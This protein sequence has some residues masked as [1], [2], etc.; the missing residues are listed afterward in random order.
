MMN[1]NTNPPPFPNGWYTIELTK[2]VQKGQI[3]AHEFCGEQVIVY[4]TQSGQA[5]V[6]EAYCPHMGAHFAHGGHVSGN[7]VVCPF[8][9]FCFDPKGTCTKTG[10]GKETPLNV[11]TRTW[12]VREQNGVIL[13][14]HNEDPTAKPEWEIPKLEDDGW[15]EPQFQ[16]W[17]LNSNPQEI[18]E[19]SVDF[20]HFSLVHGYSEVKI[21]NPLK[22]DGPYLYAKYG[23]S[24]VANFIGKGGKKVHVEFDITQNGLGY[25]AV[26]AHVI[27]YDLM[28]RHYVMPTPI[29]GTDIHLRI[30][31]SVK[32]DIQPSKIHPML[33]IMPKKLLFPLIKN[34]YFKGYKNDVFDD[35]KI[36]KNKKYVEPP[37][38]A[39]GDGPI[40]IYR[41][42]A[43]QFHPTI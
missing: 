9:G 13:A 3:I 17:Q 1:A 39:D 24:R 7:D 11:K 2:N 20:G 26:V 12:E 37:L 22:L 29:N 34:G 31:V 42:W 21:I 5:V 38:L 25:A 33:G 16:E 32:K 36:W 40:L 8:H 43:S 35:F 23:M 28:S 19:N 10:Y 15:S 14:Y 6:M 30:G 27:E 41:K 18:T 4:R